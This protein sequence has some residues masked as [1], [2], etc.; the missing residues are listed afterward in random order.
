MIARPRH[1]ALSGN[2]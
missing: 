2:E 1:F